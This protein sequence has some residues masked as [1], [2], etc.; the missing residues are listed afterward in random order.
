LE[1]LL[2]Q[3][4]KEMGIVLNSTQIQQFMFYQKLLLEWNKNIN[5]TAI[6]EEREIILKHFVDCV[7][8][9]PHIAMTEGTSVIDVGTGA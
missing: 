2:Y 4:C 7:S 6:T 8:V 9:V 3:S 5:L 1:N